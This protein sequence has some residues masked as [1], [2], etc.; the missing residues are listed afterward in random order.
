MKMDLTLDCRPQH[1]FNQMYHN[2]LINSGLFN[3]KIEKT[4]EG[5]ILEELK[6]E[7]K[8]CHGNISI[9]NINDRLVVFDT[10]PADISLSIAKMIIQHI[11]P[12]LWIKWTHEKQFE[13][14]IN[15]CPIKIWIMFPASFDGINIFDWSKEEHT[16]TALFTTGKNSYRNMGRVSWSKKSKALGFESH[17]FLPQRRYFNLLKKAVWGLIISKLNLKNTREYEYPSNGIPM[18]LNYEPQY[19]YMSF[20][21][22]KHYFKLNNVNDLEK[23][24]YE[25]PIP[26]H[27][28]SKELWN[29][30]LR[31]DKASNLLLKMLD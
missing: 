15:I 5:D 14:N 2:I 11:K 4:K 22:N 18:A 12:D 25:N 27:L 23:L 26:Y 28:K 30:Y 21:P 17:I 16:T 1:L 20:E 3:I 8:I 10:Q 7:R 13:K 19:D 31:P 29:N 9:V 24:N 6:I